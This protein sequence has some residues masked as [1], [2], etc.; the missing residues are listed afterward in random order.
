MTERCGILKKWEKN[1]KFSTIYKVGKTI[2][3]FGNTEVEKQ[4]FHQH[5]NLILI[6]DVNI[7]RIVVSK[8][9]F[10]KKDFKYFICYKNAKKVRQLCLMLPKISA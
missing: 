2:V 4:K 10:G 3:T 7:D 9:P 8:V 5:K 6:H 1:K